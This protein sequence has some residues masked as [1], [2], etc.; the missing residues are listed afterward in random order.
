MMTAPV[1]TTT[2]REWFDSA[3]AARGMWSISGRRSTV[4]IQQSHDFPRG[5]SRTEHRTG[6]AQKLASLAVLDQCRRDF[7]RRPREQFT[8]HRDVNTLMRIRR[9]GGFQE[10]AR[11]VDESR[12]ARD[13]VRGLACLQVF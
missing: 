7:L 6:I 1:P 12:V 4:L 2:K 11:L 3:A 10:V 13:A 9:H 8:P 5:K